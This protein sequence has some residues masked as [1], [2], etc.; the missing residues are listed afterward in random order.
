MTFRVEE[1][2]V[3]AIRGEEPVR[4]TTFDDGVRYMK[5]TAAKATKR[6]DRGMYDRGMKSTCPFPCPIPLSQQTG[7]G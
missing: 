2:F 6:I 5:F 7:L 1:E 3:G 4:L